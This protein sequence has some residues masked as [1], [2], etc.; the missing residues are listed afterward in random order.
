MSALLST[1]LG[2]V[3]LLGLTVTWRAGWLAAVAGCVTVTLAGLGMH[4]RERR[5]PWLPSHDRLRALLDLHIEQAE[6]HR[7]GFAELHAPALG[8]IYVEQRTDPLRAHGGEFEEQGALLGLSEMLARRRHVVVIGGP[9]SG[10][11]TLV[12]KLAG[13]A[14]IWWSS[15]R[16]LDQPRDAPLGAVFPVRLPAAELA[17]DRALPQVL[18]ES[19]ARHGLELDR[20]LFDGPRCRAS[21]GWSWW[22]VW[23][24]S[25]TPASGP[26]SCTGWPPS[27]RSRAGLTDS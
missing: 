9:G 4:A 17:N 15:A 13:D 24:R 25:R 20:S 3:G 16:R 1:G 6:S 23:T 11:S 14:A 21:T 2:A 22:T 26:T 19:H 8:R 18:A 10:K 27:W 7:Y 12:A 5:R